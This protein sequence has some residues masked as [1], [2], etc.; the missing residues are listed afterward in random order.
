M[1]RMDGIDFLEKLMRLR[2]MPVVMVSTMTQQGAEVTLRA[3][4]LGAVDFVPKP[5][6]D[7]QTGMVGLAAELVEKVRAAAR[8]RVR[9]AH[10]LPGRMHVPASQISDRKVIAIGASAGGTEALAELLA[11]LPPDAPGILIAQHMP[12]RFTRAFAERL[13]GLSAMQVSEAQDGDLVV[14]GRVLV[15]PGERHLAIR[16]EGGMPRAEV[17]RTA[18][19]NRHRP[20]VDVLFESMTVLHGDAIGVILTGMGQDGAKG[21]LAM[22]QAGARTFAQDEATS[23]IFG[24]PKAAIKCGAAEEVRPL[25]EMPAAILRAAQM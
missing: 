11:A 8:A 3:L 15:A 20:S 13:D 7:P 17:R 12:E 16:M 19:V 1:P 21:L 5:R 23:M 2:P 18:A 9:P 10:S 22:R 6:I 24:M 25:G 4:E 14:P